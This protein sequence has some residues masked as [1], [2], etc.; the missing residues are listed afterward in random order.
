[1]FLNAVVYEYTVEDTRFLFIYGLYIDSC[2]LYAF[3]KMKNE[4]FN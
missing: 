4:K 1:M 2:G 3:K